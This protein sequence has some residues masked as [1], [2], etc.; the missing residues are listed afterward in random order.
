[1]RGAVRISALMKLPA[2]WVWTHDS[3]G[4][5]EDGPTHQPIEQLAGLRAMPRLLTRIAGRLMAAAAS[6]ASVIG[7]AVPTLCA[8]ACSRK[9][10]IANTPS[11]RIIRINSGSRPA[12]IQRNRP[13]M[14]LWLSVSSAK[15]LP[16]SSLIE[17]PT[18]ILNGGYYSHRETTNTAARIRVGVGGWTF[19]PWRDNFFPAGWPHSRELEYASRKLSAI[20]VNGT[21]YSSQKPAT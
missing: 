6:A 20:E 2:I 10:T 15:S 3:I 14:A 21:Y 19:E 4:L 9:P 8:I 5:G 17:N 1:M 12:L 7:T 13:P 18:I 11:A 16:M